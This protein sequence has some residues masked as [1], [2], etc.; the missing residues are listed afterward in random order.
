MLDQNTA[1][2]VQVKYLV[3]DLV[4]LEY[5]GG[6]KSDW[7]DLRAADDVKLVAGEH[8]LIPLGV[9]IKLPEGYEA[10]IAPRSSS[11]KNWGVLQANSIGIVDESYCGN[12]DMWRWSVYA[13]R[14]I[15]IQKNDRVCQF[16]IVRHQP[17][18]IFKTVDFIDAEDRSGFGSTGTK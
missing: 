18:L 16:R 2:E 13:T 1:K 14:D 15:I 11:F 9:A 3:D 7:V 5:I 10:I 8:A 12:S 4:P 17:Q 6:G